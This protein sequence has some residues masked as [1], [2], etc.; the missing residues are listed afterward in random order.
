[1]EERRKINRVIYKANSIIVDRETQAKYYGQVKNISPMG[2]A[3]IVDAKT[4]DLVGKDVI[5]VA[6]TLIMYAD[7][8]REDPEGEGR[9]LIAFSSRKFTG[10]VLQYLFEHLGIDDI[11]DDDDEE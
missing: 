2:L 3:I 10:D 5:V 8:I 4:P 1:M 9:K 6:E 11:E 7:V